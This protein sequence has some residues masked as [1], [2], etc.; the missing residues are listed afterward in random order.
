MRI[1]MLIGPCVGALTYLL[2]TA[3]AGLLTVKLSSLL[4]T[5]AIALTQPYFLDHCPC[6]PPLVE[7]RRMAAQIAVPLT[8]KKDERA[9]ASEAPA[10]S[11]GILAAQMDLAEQA[12]LAQSMRVSQ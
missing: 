9:P 8:T 2:A 7:Q 6:L 5:Q 4:A 11:V 12:D 10:I 1:R 3:G